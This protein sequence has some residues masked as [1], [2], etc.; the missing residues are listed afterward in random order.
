MK[1]TS[2][3]NNETKTPVSGIKANK[4]KSSRFAYEQHLQNHFANNLSEIEEGLML[5]TGDG[6]TGVEYSIGG[7][8]IDILALDKDGNFVVIEFKRSRGDRE[9]IAQLFEYIGLVQE[10]LAAVGQK[11][12]GLI[13]CNTITRDLELACRPV[14]DKGI[15]LFEYKQ[16]VELTKKEF[17]MTNPNVLE[18]E[19]FVELPEN[20]GKFFNYSL[21]NSLD[22]IGQAIYA[23]TGVKFD[24]DEVAWELNPRLSVSVKD[25]MNRYN[26][27]YSM[28]IW[29]EEG[30][31][32]I[33]INRRSGNKWFYYFPQTKKEAE[34][35][36][37]YDKDNAY[38]LDD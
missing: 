25:L 8:R 22:E 37:H 12:R 21:S 10:K 18:E 16:S 20:T 6:H 5:F 28:T 19:I 30:H 3:G 29:I 36:V 32:S 9:V 27:D 14:R 35:K 24:L 1:D 11:V 2:D 34:A 31:R 15:D 7:K 23:R 13:I 33:I 26:V 17:V 4:M 38:L